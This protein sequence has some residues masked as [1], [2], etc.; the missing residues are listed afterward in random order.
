[1]IHASIHAARPDV[2]AIAHAHTIYGKVFSSL[3]ISID[4]INLDACAFYNDHAIYNDF[5]GV[6]IELDEGLRLVNAL[7]SKKALI[8]QNHGHLVVGATVD[9]AAWWFINME[10][11]FQAQLLVMSSGKKPF[12]IKHESALQTYSITGTAIGGWFQFQP[13]Y[14]RIL[15]EQPDF[16]E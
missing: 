4:P 9:A 2:L 13:M 10:R 1:M 6:V 3:G 12:H 7:G 8:M 5:G 16:L 15:K 14:D 11:S